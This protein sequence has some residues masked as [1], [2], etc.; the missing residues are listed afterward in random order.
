MGDL[1]LRWMALY[2]R[3]DGLEETKYF[4]YLENG[5]W[6]GEV[7]GGD[8]TLICIDVV[9]GLEMGNNDINDNIFEFLIAG[10]VK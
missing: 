6:L 9:V 8:E 5:N 2:E 4:G 1:L 7:N 3:N 10:V